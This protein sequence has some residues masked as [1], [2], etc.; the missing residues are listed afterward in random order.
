[1]MIRAA[2]QKDSGSISELISTLVLKYI[3]PSCSDS[4]AQ[5]LL[6]SMDANSIKSYIEQGYQYH[7]GEVNNEIIGVVAVKENS[8]LYHLF[9]D[10]L[11]QGK[12]FAKQL[13]EHA[14]S[15]CIKQGNNGTFTVNSALNAV[16][17]Y[18]KWGFIPYMNVRERG[19]VK[20]LPMRLKMT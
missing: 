5:V 15:L 2:S 4:G 17:V 9:I 12:G 14:K 19:G 8:H 1:M 10:D 11:H 7:V 18:K 16:Q 3:A 6:N 20:D 13:W